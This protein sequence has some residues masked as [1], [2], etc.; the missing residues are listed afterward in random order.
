MRLLDFLFWHYYSYMEQ[1]KTVKEDGAWPAIIMII[2][3]TSAIIGSLIGDVEIFI[4][5][6]PLPESKGDLKYKVYFP[7]SILY[8]L[9]LRYRYMK[10]ESV[11]KNKY[12][13]FRNRWGDPKHV[14]KKNM[15]I[16]LIYTLIT[17]IGLLLV[18]I[19]IGELNKRG[20]FTGC[21][22]FP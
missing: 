15:R 10:Q 5:D 11:V 3:T 2:A 4:C 17:T 8:I 18:S 22:L 16:L 7:I 12:E 20:F 9:F 1:K 14:S 6:L 21:R 19:I 13:V